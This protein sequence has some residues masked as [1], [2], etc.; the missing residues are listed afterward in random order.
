MKNKIIV[1]LTGLILL[2]PLVGCDS[3]T[4]SS[5]EPKKNPE[6][7][8]SVSFNEDNLVYDKKT[9]I[10]YI[11]NKSGSYYIYT[12]YI[13]ENGYYCKLDDDKIVEINNQKE[14]KSS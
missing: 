12:P 14:S 5:Q 4:S 6:V 8:R 13:S 7:T 10:I 2:V 1:L 3:S 11:R 9:K